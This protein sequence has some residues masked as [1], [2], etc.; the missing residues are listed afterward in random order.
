MILSRFNEP[1]YKSKFIK[2]IKDS[3][4]H[5]DYIIVTGDLANAGTE[6]EYKLVFKFLNDLS[7]ELSINSS[8]FFICPGNHDINWGKNEIAF[9]DKAKKV[10]EEGNTRLIEKEEA[11]K[12]HNEKFE[13]FIEFYKSFHSKD[14]FKFNPIDF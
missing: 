10:L 4:I 5:I 11:Y 6:K 14:E 3:G 7:K 1:N 8:D 12:F 2:K 9:L 13:D